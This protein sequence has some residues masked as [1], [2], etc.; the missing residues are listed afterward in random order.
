MVIPT[1]ANCAP[2]G[3]GGGDLD[4]WNVVANVLVWGLQ[5]RLCRLIQSSVREYSVK[6]SSKDKQNGEKS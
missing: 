1:R 2:G 3:G 6:A 5:F 4:F